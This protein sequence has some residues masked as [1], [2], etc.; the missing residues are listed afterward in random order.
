MK[1]RTQRT[2]QLTPLDTRDVRTCFAIMPFNI[3]TDASRGD[4]LNF[5]TKVYDN[6]IEPAVKMAQ[7]EGR[8]PISVTRADKV[9]RAGSIHERMIQ[10]IADADVAIVDLTT[11]NPNVFYELG[12]RHALRDRVTVLIR[13]RGTK[14]SFNIAGLATI[15]YDEKRPDAAR[16]TI[17]AFIR[18]GLLSGAK[19]SLVYGMLPDL[20]VETRRAPTIASDVE[21][22]D[23]PGS[24][25][26]RLG[27]VMG[28]LRHVNLTATLRTQPIDVWVNSEN[29]NMSMARPYE[30]NISA[31][32][33]YL[34]ARKDETG[35]IID[36]VVADELK[37]KMN[38]RQVVNPGEVVVTDA[39]RLTETHQVK[40]IFHAASVYGVV[41]YGFQP[42]AGI[43][44]CVTNALARM[45]FEPTK[46]VKRTAGHNRAKAHLESILF[47]L[48]GSGTARA[49]LIA[50]ARKQV[51][52][53]VRYL[54][55]RAE[56]TRVTRVYFLAP[57]AVHCAALRVTFAEQGLVR[58]DR[59]ASRE[60]K[61]PV[62][63]RRKT[64]GAR[65]TK[66]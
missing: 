63:K 34:G 7:D 12:V 66:R 64:S 1:T 25:G 8:L 45:D 53:A 47:P 11:A 58:T 44:Q 37:K 14:S 6:I 30:S 18:N 9:L 16:Q 56:F 19:D 61:P 22:Y 33:R 3:K 50:S 15:D 60:R 62:R 65:S 40:Q 4:T 13:R 20:R 55:S 2:Q 36:D 5:D 46:G 35:A 41:G 29:V 38:R 59:T 52:A 39:G 51:G 10:L 27:I 57:T 28:E 49:D 48:L 26:K 43:E 21:E 32:I 31:T 23:M 42:I 54:R 24:P 17:A